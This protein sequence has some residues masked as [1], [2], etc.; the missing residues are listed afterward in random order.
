EG[1]GGDV[2]VRRRLVQRQRRAAHG[3]AAA[4]GLPRLGPLATRG[5]RHRRPDGP[6]RRL[7]RPPPGR[8]R[9]GRRPLSH[10]RRQGGRVR[11]PSVSRSR[12][13]P[14]APADFRNPPPP[15]PNTPSSQGPAPRARAPALQPPNR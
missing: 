15:P 5:A 12:A 6:P 4:G 3:R 9:E 14:P 13:Q 2:G 10:L 8:G 11:R 7:P 1:T